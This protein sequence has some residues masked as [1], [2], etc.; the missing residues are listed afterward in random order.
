[1]QTFWITHRSNVKYYCETNH[2]FNT[3][4]LRF[5]EVKWLVQVPLLVGDRSRI[6]LFLTFFPSS[7]WYKQGTVHRITVVL[8]SLTNSGSIYFWERKN[9]GF[10]KGGTEL[11]FK[12]AYIAL[13]CHITIKQNSFATENPALL[14]AGAS[15]RDASASTMLR[16]WC[17]FW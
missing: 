3:R 2:W 12:H 10:L 7:V 5:S 17:F 1:M 4:S 6:D 14:I 13:T 15:A 8:G 9:T 16:M 11:R